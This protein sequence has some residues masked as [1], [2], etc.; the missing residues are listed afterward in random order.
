[1]IT[2]S[3]L[4]YTYPTLW[5]LKMIIHKCFSNYCS[6]ER[7]ILLEKQIYIITDFVKIFT[8]DLGAIYHTHSLCFRRSLWSQ[9]KPS[10]SKW[11]TAAPTRMEDASTCQQSTVPFWVVL[12]HL[13][14]LVQKEFPSYWTPCYSLGLITDQY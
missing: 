4:L 1:M 9:F 11:D 6:K 8:G 5:T 2:A 7:E 12:D 13:V 3:I 14:V 10:I